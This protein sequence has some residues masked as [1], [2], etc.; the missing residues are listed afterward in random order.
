MRSCITISSD[1]N[2]ELACR[3]YTVLLLI[4]E[5]TLVKQSI[6]TNLLW[7]CTWVYLL[8]YILYKEITKNIK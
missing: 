4:L 8:N 6:T 2:V 7:Q 1:R 3:L 5:S